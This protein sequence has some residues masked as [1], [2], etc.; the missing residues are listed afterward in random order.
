MTQALHIFRKDLRHQWIDLVIY[1]ALLVLSGFL[2]PT[3]WP[4]RWSSNDMLPWLLILLQ[5]AVP[6][7]WLVMIARLVHEEAIVGDRQF[8]TTRPYRW[9]SLLGAKLLFLA[10][11]IALPYFVMQWCIALYGGLSPFVAGF[12]MSAAMHL[13]IVWIPMFLFACVTSTLI[14]TFF[15]T[16]GS[17]VLW[18][19]T[20]V[21]L[22]GSNGPEAD[23]PF[24]RLYFGALFTGI[25]AFLLVFL[26]RKRSFRLGRVLMGSSA[27]LF[28][29]LIVFVSKMSPSSL[30][31]QLLKARYR[32]GAAPQLHLQYV[33]GRFSG[34]HA[35]DS[36]WLLAVPVPIEL[37][38]LSNGHRLHNAAMQ[39][40]LEAGGYRYTSPWRPTALTPEGMTF[41]VP[42]AVLDHAEHADAHLTVSLAAEEIA[43]DQPQTTTLRDR[44]AI[45]G[46]GS[47]DAVN[48][49]YEHRSAAT[50]VVCHFAYSV[51][52]PIEIDANME[53]GCP[54]PKLPIQV[55]TYDGGTGFD[56]LTH[57]TVRAGLGAP[58]V[59][60][61]VVQSVTTT[62]YRP[63]TRFRTS[64]DIPSIRL[65]DYVGH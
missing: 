65:A 10:I 26:Y 29:L 28:L 35:Q 1:A 45:P 41:R 64:L 5:V 57:W 9:S 54:V 37:L 48:P 42:R 15:T 46:G 36:S 44:F 27:V 34:H 31:T 38:G 56:P 52:Y 33:P 62:V 17:V 25:F 23:A 61:C 22:L 21:F 30:G 6:L 4:G 7:F 60:A 11:C 53:P 16:L 20:L 43:P 12:P 3:K 2:V 24:A 49:P 14:S 55:P 39:Y 40:H 19:A 63:V 47:C 58:E 18:V 13:L 59:R 51:P 50:S 32:D 8:W